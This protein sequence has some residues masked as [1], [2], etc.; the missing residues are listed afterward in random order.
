MS[1]WSSSSR[2]LRAGSIVPQQKGWESG[3]RTITCYVDGA[4]EAPVT[5]SLKGSKK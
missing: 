4:D 5:G 1:A 2:R 3:E